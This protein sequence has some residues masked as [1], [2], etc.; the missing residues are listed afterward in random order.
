MN[1]KSKIV[2]IMILVTLLFLATSFIPRMYPDEGTYL[3]Y[4]ASWRRG[5]L[6]P[7]IEIPVVHRPAFVSLAFLVSGLPLPLARLIILPFVLGSFL[8]AFW[9]GE[10]VD[11]PGELTSLPMLFSPIL[12]FYFGTILTDYVVLFFVL[13]SIYFFLRSVNEWGE[14][15]KWSWLMGLSLSL[16][17]LTKESALLLVPVFL[18]FHSKIEFKRFLVSTFAPLVGYTLLVGS[19]M[20]LFLEYS[21]SYS[22]PIALPG[23]SSF[24]SM[25][26][27]GLGPVLLLLLWGR[28]NLDLSDTFVRFS[29][30]Y[31]LLVI[32]G[33][34]LLSATWVARYTIF[35]LPGLLLPS[36]KGLARVERNRVMALILI[37][38]LV[39]SGA[40]VFARFRQA[41]RNWG[42]QRYL[43]GVESISSYEDGLVYM[44]VNDEQIRWLM[45]SD[46]FRKLPRTYEELEEKTS[47]EDV[48]VFLWKF[49]G[50]VIWEPDYWNE[51]AEFSE[52]LE[53]DLGVFGRIDCLD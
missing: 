8:L 37:V 13:L 5:N 50:N 6:V 52:V 11:L 4:G 7:E 39:L 18:F 34:L 41:Q 44:Q 9:I 29:L 3:N 31:C 10:E 33:T 36:A 38:S 45:G 2:S 49:D 30:V 19:S 46:R 51:E 28:R 43:D 15:N 53:T 14:R 23:L 40:F 21:L 25:F 47:C 24:I 48:A 20:F 17:V 12:L 16:A 1:R 35:F 22:Y 27:V 42:V 32:A 26:M